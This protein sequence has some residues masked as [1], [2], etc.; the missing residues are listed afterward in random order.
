MFESAVTVGDRLIAV[1]VDVRPSA[2]ESDIDM[3]GDTA[4]MIMD[5]IAELRSLDVDQ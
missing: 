1:D 2:S 3:S 5:R 4:Y